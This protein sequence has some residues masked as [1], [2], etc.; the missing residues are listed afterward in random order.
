MKATATYM[1]DQH[2]LRKIKE[3]TICV[4]QDLLGSQVHLRK[5]NMMEKRNRQE[6]ATEKE[7]KK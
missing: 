3:K 1:A 4:Q 2:R 7:K 6:I 5:I